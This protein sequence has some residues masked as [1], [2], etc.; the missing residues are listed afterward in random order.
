MVLF[1][2]VN[3]LAKSTILADILSKNGHNG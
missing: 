1:Y 2:N 3:N